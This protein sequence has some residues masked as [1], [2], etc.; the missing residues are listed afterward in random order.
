MASFWRL[1]HVY[2]LSKYEKDNLLESYMESPNTKLCT[3]CKIEKLF[4]DFNKDNSRKDKLQLHCKQCVCEWRI[5]NKEAISASRRDYYEKN[6][7]AL[8]LKSKQHYEVNKI[9]IL[10][11]AKDYRENNRDKCLEYSKEYYILNKDSFKDY[12][13]NNRDKIKS[14]MKKYREDNR[15][16]L[17]K[18][19]SEYREEN[20]EYLTKVSREYYEINKIK[21]KSRLNNYRKTNPDKFLALNAKRRACKLNATPVWLTTEDFNEIEELYVCARMFKLYTG[22]E[23]HVDHIIP[24]QG[25]TVCGL[26]VPWNLQ[27]I[28]A[29]ENLCKSNKIEMKEYHGTYFS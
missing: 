7:E 12:R 19:N 6:K 25:K 11:K 16:A 9:K 5:K 28:P 1:S 23:Y 24:L 29:K 8:S 21:C 20:K 27:V 13:E 2:S 26:H 15:D 18:Y 4:S 10:E 22:E 3:K 17:S 14:R